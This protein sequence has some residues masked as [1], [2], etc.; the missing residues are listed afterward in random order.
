MEIL[1]D[2][3]GKVS[4][5]IPDTRLETL[6]GQ[7]GDEFGD[8]GDMAQDVTQTRNEQPLNNMMEMTI[9]EISP[10]VDVNKPTLDEVAAYWYTTKEIVLSELKINQQ[11]KLI[12]LYLDQLVDDKGTQ[13]RLAF[14]SRYTKSLGKRIDK[15]LQIEPRNNF[16]FLFKKMQFMMA[17]EGQQDF[18]ES[19]VDRVKREKK[20]EDKLEVGCK[21]F[22]D[23]R[24]H[25]HIFNMIKTNV[26]LNE[27]DFL[28]G[29]VTTLEAGTPKSGLEFMLLNYG[30]FASTKLSEVEAAK[31]AELKPFSDDYQ[32]EFLE[33]VD[34]FTTNYSVVSSAYK[35]LTEYSFDSE[36]TGKV[37]DIFTRLLRKVKI[38]VLE[39]IKGQPA[40]QRDSQIAE[41]KTTV[42][43]VVTEVIA[44]VISFML[45]VPFLRKG[46]KLLLNFLLKKVIVFILN[47]L[48]MGFNKAKDF[49]KEFRRKRYTGKKAYL[50]SLDYEMLIDDNLKVL[51]DD[52]DV[53]E[54]I[55]K[56]ITAME[57][58]FYDNAFNEVNIFNQ[59]H[60]NEVYQPSGKRAQIINFASWHGSNYFA[61]D[62][63]GA[64]KM[65]D[66][67]QA[68]DN[69][70]AITQ[71]EFR[72]ISVGKKGQKPNHSVRL[73]QLEDVE[74]KLSDRKI[75]D[76]LNLVGDFEDVFDN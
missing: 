1:D 11:K 35:D 75:T 37:K 20:G 10:I 53:K 3:F 59:M 47:K 5:S 68:Y 43:N 45:F 58:I 70:K 52:K 40:I 39:K 23:S 50:V 9:N 15:S 8:G 48:E 73:R 4:P 51:L 42:V 17:S 27:T 65:E 74:R 22:Q 38:L 54:D 26:I 25:Y 61:F 41:W 12:K 69:P 18:L 71:N 2:F 34:R 36:K 46:I 44:D 13:D 7:F 19:N 72:D 30:L 62:K 67:S 49:Y 63:A 66:H 29:F 16:E 14:V 76:E 28:K 60:K 55:K 56:D 32:R 33:A 24:L 31:F 21:C 64:L 6:Q 57:Q